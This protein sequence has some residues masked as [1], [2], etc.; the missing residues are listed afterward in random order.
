M[1]RQLS[2]LT[3]RLFVSGSL[4]SPLVALPF[5]FAQQQPVDPATLKP[6]Q[7]QWQPERAPNGPVVVLVSIPKQWVVVYRG[8]VRIAASS[9]STGKPGHKTPA[10]V[11]VVLA[12]VQPQPLRALAKAHW[13]NVPGSLAIGRNFEKALAVARAHASGIPDAGDLD[14]SRS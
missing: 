5:A 4:A 6:N 8:G 9:C 2:P 13:R 14:A 11:F 7:F 1:P 3:R 10:G 12:G